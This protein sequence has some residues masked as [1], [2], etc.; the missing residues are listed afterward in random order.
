MVFYQYPTSILP[1]TL[2]WNIPEL[3]A[4]D[5][6]EP[7]AADEDLAELVHLQTIK[8]MFYIRNKPNECINNYADKMYLKTLAIKHFC[9]PMLGGGAVCM[10]TQ[11]FFR[12]NMWRS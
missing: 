4:L 2:A 3:L 10:K 12:L 1:E 8:Y 9:S 7:V 5:E 11:T 6:P